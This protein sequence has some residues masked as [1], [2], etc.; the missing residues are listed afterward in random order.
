MKLKKGSCFNFVSGLLMRPSLFD[1]VCG[2]QEM[3][4]EFDSEQE[5]SQE[6][7]GHI[8]A[9]IFT[10]EVKD[11]IHLADKDEQIFNALEA[12]R[13]TYFAKHIKYDMNTMI[14]SN[15]NDLSA[16]I[17]AKNNADLNQYIDINKKLYSAMDFIAKLK[18]QNASRKMITISK[19]LR[20]DGLKLSD[21][22]IF[23]C[24]DKAYNKFVGKD[25][26]LKLGL[27]L[28]NRC[29]NAEEQ[30]KLF[31]VVDCLQQ[32]NNAMREKA[33]LNEAL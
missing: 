32:K 10:L 5:S 13:Q 7:E 11:L 31:D 29:Y 2:Q 20:Q 16:A 25:K 15:T 28:H 1:Y 23:I 19:Q 6:N 18:L 22:Q 14:Y 17:E 33:K 26:N 9:Q 30:Q 12:I 8:S 4:C 3:P 24:I 27:I 21:M